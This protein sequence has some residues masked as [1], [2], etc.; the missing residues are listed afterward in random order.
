MDG[1]TLKK[2]LWSLVMAGNFSMLLLLLCFALF[3]VKKIRSVA[4][5]LFFLNCAFLLSI[6]YTPLAQM[7]ISYLEK[8]YPK[9]FSQDTE[10]REATGFVV[11]G[12][13]IDEDLSDLYD[14]PQ[15]NGNSDRAIEFLSLIKQYPNKRFVFTGGSPHILERFK[16]RKN[17][18]DYFKDYLDQQKVDLKNIIFERESRDTIENARLT[19]NLINPKSDEKWVLITS[20]YHMPRSVALFNKA[21]WENIIP[22]PVD[23]R[24][25]KQYHPSLTDN[26]KLFEIAQKE[27]LALIWYRANNQI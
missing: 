16:S 23:Y 25:K 18:S 24:S 2:I 17:E 1:F 6:A 21:G 9:R 4:V 14:A 5:V 10:I 11:L 8:Q 22:Y 13:F 7:S 12:G 26:L 27:F 20:A 15:F 19:Y 3:F